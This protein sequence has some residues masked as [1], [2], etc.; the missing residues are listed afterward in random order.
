MWG[1]GLVMTALAVVATVAVGRADAAVVYRYVAEPV[2]GEVGGK[3]QV[4]VFLEE[5]LT[6]GSVSVVGGES[7]LFGAGFVFEWVGGRP[8]AIDSVTRNA[9]A[10]GGLS[11]VSVTATTV[12]VLQSVPLAATTGVMP[13]GNGRVLLGTVSLNSA[14]AT[15]PTLFRVGRLDTLGGNTITFAG[16][17]LDFDSTTPAFTGATT[18]T[19]W[20]RV[21]VVPEP[22]AAAGLAFAV[23]LTAGR[24]RRRGA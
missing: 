12:R 1:R 17:D 7:G 15:G 9:G 4:N 2:G 16:T 24:R 6:G 11:S 23:F 18:P 22:G 5:S 8:L 3:S 10:F 20:F 14:A 19:P 21:A 13:D